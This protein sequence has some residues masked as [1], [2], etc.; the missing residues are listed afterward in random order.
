MNSNSKAMTPEER[1]RPF[2]FDVVVVISKSIILQLWTV[3]LNHAQNYAVSVHGSVY[4]AINQVAITA[5]TIASCACLSTKV[6]FL[7]PK[8]DQQPG[9]VLSSLFA[10]CYADSES[11]DFIY[12]L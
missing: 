5:V 9:S 11:I 10:T 7:W 8:L 1:R 12:N 3:I 2:S 6:D 4:S